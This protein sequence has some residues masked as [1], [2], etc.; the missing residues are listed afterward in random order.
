M[1][2]RDPQLTA[3]RKTKARLAGDL[4][5]GGS[6]SNDAQWK[7]RRSLYHTCQMGERAGRSM[8]PFPNAGIRLHY[9]VFL[10][11]TIESDRN[12]WPSEG[13]QKMSVTPLQTLLGRETF[14][15]IPRLL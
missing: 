15:H 5:Q 10:A 14:A 3:R 4:Q 11:A 6:H 12:S 13:N 8:A 9:G 7:E 2:H 1:D